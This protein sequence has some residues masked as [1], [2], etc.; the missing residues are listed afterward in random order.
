MQVWHNIPEQFVIQFV[1][2]KTGFNRLSQKRHFVE[3][4]PAM[5]AQLAEFAGVLA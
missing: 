1:G 4:G 3:K 2:P 5:G